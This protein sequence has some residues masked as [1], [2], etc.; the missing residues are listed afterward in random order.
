MLEQCH[1]RGHCFHRADTGELFVRHDQLR[2][3]KAAVTCCW[4]EKAAELEQYSK[5]TKPPAPSSYR[6]NLEH[7]PY[8]PVTETQPGVPS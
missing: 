5:G 7:G 8:V 1:H 4:C 2:P 6:P 3:G